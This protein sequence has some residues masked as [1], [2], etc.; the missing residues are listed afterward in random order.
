MGDYKVGE[1]K[2]GEYKL[3]EYKMGEKWESTRWGPT[4]SRLS[5]VMKV[6]VI[7]LHPSK[8]IGQV[9]RFISSCQSERLAKLGSRR[10]LIGSLQNVV[11]AVAAMVP[12]CRVVTTQGRDAAE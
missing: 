5:N 7:C 4:R 12:R 6:I 2:M 9:T 11:A 3:R 8:L 10:R 1:Y